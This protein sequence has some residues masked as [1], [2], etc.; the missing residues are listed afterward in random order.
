MTLHDAA[1]EPIPSTEGIPCGWCGLRH[2]VAFTLGRIKVAE[3]EKAPRG[4]E[5]A[6]VSPGAWDN[7]WGDDA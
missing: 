5:A 7:Q 1:G 4:Y 2:P 3:C 6:V